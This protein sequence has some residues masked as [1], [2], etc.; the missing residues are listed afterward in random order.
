MS[1]TTT[2]FIVLLIQYLDMSITAKYDM[3]C[4]DIVEHK[5]LQRQEKGCSAEHDIAGIIL[6]ICVTLA[7]LGSIIGNEFGCRI[8][9][10]DTRLPCSGLPGRL[11]KMFF[12]T[13][14]MSTCSMLQN[15]ATL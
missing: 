15:S 13:F 6:N 11:T 1:I 3:Y 2:V 7:K 4:C 5:C 8:F 12:S 9:S 14:N 10:K